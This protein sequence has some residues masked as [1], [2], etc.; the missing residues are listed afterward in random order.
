MQ[1]VVEVNLEAGLG[2]QVVLINI[3][4][5]LLK[6]KEAGHGSKLTKEVGGINTR[7]KNHKSQT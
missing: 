1:G 7:L 4:K 5:K 6:T 3:K 2:A